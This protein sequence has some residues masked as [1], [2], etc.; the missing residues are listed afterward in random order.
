MSS[1]SV[2]KPVRLSGKDAFMGTSFTND[3]AMNL[4]KSDDY[5]ARVVSSDAEGW[6]LVL[7]AKSPEL[8][9]P[10]IVARVG[11]DYLPR[12]MAYFARSGKESKRV[13]FSEP[14]DFGGKIRPS[15]FSLVDL[16]KPGD[17]SRLVFLEIREVALSRSRFLPSSL[18]K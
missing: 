1:P 13:D 15:A 11:R 2:S 9:Y 7:S 18:G 14:K 8:P 4:D 6:D 5:D 16:M 17:K 3:D 12:Q 10:K